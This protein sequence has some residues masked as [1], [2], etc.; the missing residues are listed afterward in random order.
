MQE[1]KRLEAASTFISLRTI[2]AAPRR[3]ADA[4]L[5]VIRSAMS[6][7]AEREISFAGSVEAA[8]VPVLKYKIKNN[9]SSSNAA[10]THSLITTH[11][12]PERV[13]LLVAFKAFD[14]AAGHV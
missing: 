2:T 9:N 8:P 1:N 3:L 13:A 10:V 14:Y 6:D 7:G 12:P 4:A 11:N 5:Y